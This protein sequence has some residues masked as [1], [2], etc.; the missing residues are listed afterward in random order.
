MKTLSILCLLILSACGTEPKKADWVYPEFVK[1]YKTFGTF[2]GKRV[3]LTHGIW[4]T[5]ALYDGGYFGNLK[6]GL[7]AKGFQVITFSYPYTDGPIMRDGGKIYR[8]QYVEFLQWLIQDANQR[9]G[10][11]TELDIGG[12]SFGGLHA[13]IGAAALPFNKY[14]AIVPVS[15]P[16]I[17][18]LFGPYEATYFN[19][20]NEVSVLSTKPG[21][22]TTAHGDSI[23]GYLPAQN[24]ASQIGCQYHDYMGIVG[25]NVSNEMITDLIN[26]F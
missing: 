6:A 26:W 14:A 21:F 20:F 24:L 19:A 25:H 10:V 17:S 1:T 9:Y 4:D 18:G 8:E 23:L 7:I 16:K 5:D 15:D 22:I 12:F 3:L 13:M 11:A 2:T